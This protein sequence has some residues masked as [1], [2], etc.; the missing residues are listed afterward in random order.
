[1]IEGWPENLPFKNLSEFSSS[2]TDLENLLRRWESGATHWRAVSEEELKE[3]D[4]KRNADIDDGTIE[5][6]Q[7]RRRSDYGKKRVR[8]NNSSSTQGT[9]PSKK[10]RSNSVISTE[11]EDGGT[12][13]TTSSAAAA[14]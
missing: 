8:N 6:P 9:R 1:M 5:E 3:M 2:I 10:R 7:R 12:T 13:T 14:V 4:K 11:D